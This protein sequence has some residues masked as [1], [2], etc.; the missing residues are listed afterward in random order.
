VNDLFG[1]NNEF[2]VLTLLADEN[3]LFDSPIDFAYPEGERS[4][5]QLFQRRYLFS[6]L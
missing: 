4:Y 2:K 5:S 3:M 1:N 6:F